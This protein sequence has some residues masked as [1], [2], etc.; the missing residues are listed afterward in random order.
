MYKIHLTDLTFIRNLV[1]MSRNTLTLLLLDL[2]ANISAPP[3]KA[4]PP[5]GLLLALQYEKKEQHT[6]KITKWIG[7]TKTIE[8]ADINISFYISKKHHKN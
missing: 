8:I 1:E 2:L 5:A 4:T 6:V 3:N 7:I